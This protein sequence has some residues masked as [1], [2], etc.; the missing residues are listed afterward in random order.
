MTKYFSDLSAWRDL[1]AGDFNRGYLSG[2]VLVLAVV[3]LILVIRIVLSFIF[4][5]RR[6]RSIVV[7]AADGEVMISQNAVI[8]AVESML[9]GFPELLVDSVK[10][11]RKG[12]MYSF[13]L[14][15]RFQVG[16]AAVFPDVAQ[17]M[18]EAV[19]AGM[20]EQ[21]G[22]DNLRRI[23]IVLTELEGNKLPKAETAASDTVPAVTPGLPVDQM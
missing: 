18:K 8:A 21:F 4:R 9:A 17:K 20:R 22:V 11:Y 3:L 23:R 12:R 2:V 5:N 13:L 10:I 19:F 15:C 16:E 7:P 1:L 14:H 6:V